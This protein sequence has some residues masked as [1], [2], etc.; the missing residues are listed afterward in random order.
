MR[1]R[2]VGL[3]AATAIASAAL[4]GCSPP[5]ENPSDIKITDQSNPVTTYEQ[6]DETETDAEDGGVG[7]DETGTGEGPASEEPMETDTFE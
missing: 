1:N 6:G 7:T 5:N 3:A 4:V 2:L